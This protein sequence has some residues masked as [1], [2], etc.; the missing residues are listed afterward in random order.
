MIFVR[1]APDC[2]HVH[3]LI[4]RN[5]PDPSVQPWRGNAE[6]RRRSS[7]FARFLIQNA[8]LVPS[9]VHGRRRQSASKPASS[10]E[11]GSHRVIGYDAGASNIPAIDASA[12]KLSGKNTSGMSECPFPFLPRSGGEGGEAGRR[13]PV[14]RSAPANARRPSGGIRRCSVG[15]RPC[16]VASAK[17]TGCR[18]LPEGRRRLWLRDDLDQAILPPELAGVRDVAEDL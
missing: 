9:E 11:S 17:S 2:G 16:E 5:E 18:A 4:R 1:P 14:G 3:P 12:A 6:Q 15:R 8:A 7:A 10:F 13:S